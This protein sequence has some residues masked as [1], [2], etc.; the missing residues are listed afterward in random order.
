MKHTS[1]V[2]TVVLATAFM[3][4]QQSPEG[5]AWFTGTFDEALASARARGTMLMLDFYSPN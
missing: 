3:G 1:M 2:A 4:C 5:P